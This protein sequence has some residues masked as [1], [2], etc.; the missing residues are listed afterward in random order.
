M[1]MHQPVQVFSLFSPQRM[2]E[3]LRSATLGSQALGARSCKEATI[4]KRSM[5]RCETRLLSVHEPL[6]SC[7]HRRVAWTLARSSSRFSD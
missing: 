2:G 3:T 6:L 1:L 4:L 5:G 7:P